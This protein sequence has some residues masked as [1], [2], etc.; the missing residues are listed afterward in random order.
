MQVFLSRKYTKLMRIKLVKALV[1]VFTVLFSYKII[2][3][4][5]YWNKILIYLLGLMFVGFNWSDYQFISDMKLT[6]DG[7][8]LYILS[9]FPDTS[10]VKEM[11]DSTRS[12][13]KDIINYRDHTTVA[14]A[15]GDV[16]QD[17]VYVIADNIP[18]V[19]SI[20]KDMKENMISDG[21]NKIWPLSDVFSNPMVLLAIITGITLTGTII[22]YHYD[23]TLDQVT[24]YTWTHIKLGFF[25]TVSFIAKLARFFLGKNNDPRPPMEPNNDPI[26]LNPALDLNKTPTGKAPM[27]LP[28]SPQLDDVFPILSEASGSNITLDSNHQNFKGFGETLGPIEELTS[29]VINNIDL[30]HPDSLKLFEENDLKI[31]IINK[32]LDKLNQEIVNPTIQHLKNIGLRQL[33]N[34]YSKFPK[35]SESILPYDVTTATG[36]V[37][38]TIKSPVIS[39]E[40]LE[41]PFKDMDL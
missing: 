30:D 1:G 24:E 9:Y 11:K 23:I 16:S 22:V 33:K 40:N 28:R 10:T 21:E 26:D 8:K 27:V 18:E 13:I 19:K 38:D 2:K 36:S 25:A 34:I 4:L 39:P 32:E 14:N 29:S 37:S 35:K 3:Y 7:I 17:Y 12:D 5:V 15:T 6:F 20:R 31:K 41:N